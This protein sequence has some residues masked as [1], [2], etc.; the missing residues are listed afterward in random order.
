MGFVSDHDHRIER[1]VE[2]KNHPKHH[3][4]VSKLSLQFAESLLLFYIICFEEEDQDCCFEEDQDR[5][6]HFCCFE[7]DDAE[8]RPSTLRSRR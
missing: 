2:L 5:T 8:D 1:D 4:I 3:C 7:E 6:I